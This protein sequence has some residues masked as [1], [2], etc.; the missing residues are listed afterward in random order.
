[1][2]YEFQVVYRLTAPGGDGGPAAMA[3]WPALSSGPLHTITVRAGAP[4]DAKQMVLTPGLAVVSVGPGRPILPE[5]PTYNLE[6]AAVYLDVS[7]RTL[8]ELQGKGD[9]PRPQKNGHTVFR[10]EELE[11]YRSRA[12][13][14]QEWKSKEVKG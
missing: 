9:L 4:E 3:S 6:E 12:M 2:I 7:E 13:K 5:K 1:M 10:V 11:L 14:L 8:R